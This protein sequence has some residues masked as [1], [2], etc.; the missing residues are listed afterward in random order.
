MK[1]HTPV[2][3]RQ[4]GTV[5]VTTLMCL[6]FIAVMGLSVLSLTLHGL[7]TTRR[8]ESSTVAFNLAESGLDR[9]LRWLKNQP[10]PPGG[11]AAF[12][13]FGGN[14]TMTGG[15]YNVVVTPDP[16]NMGSSL[17]RYGI[18]AT[19]YAGEEVEVVEL[20]VRQT[21]FGKYA[22]FTDRETSAVSG[23]RIWFFSGDRIR[24]P[25]H[26]NNRSGSEFQINWGGPGPI[27]EDSVTSS[28]SFINYSPSNPN[29]ESQF[30]QIYLAGSRGYELN[31][32]EIA[33]PPSSDIQKVAAWGNN[34]AYPGVN[35]VYTPFQ[36][37]IYI[38][39]D[40]AVTMSVDGSGRQRFVIVQSGTTTTLTVD[41]A[42][43]VI[44]KQVGAGPVV[45][46]PGAG[47][48]VVY[49]TGNITSLS[50]TIANNTVLAGSPP[51]VQHRSA[52]TIATDVNAGRNITVT[53]PIRHQTAYNPALGPNAAANLNPGTLGLIGRNVTVGSGCPTNMEIDAV[54]M[55]GSESTTDGS[56]GVAN[57]NTKVPTG[58]LKV[59]GGIIQKARGAV[60]TLSG[61]LLATGYAKDYHY[62]ARMA[63]NPPPFFP[64]T[65]GYDRL[66]WRRMVDP[67]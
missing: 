5:L 62:D 67:D 37:G 63:D 11:L 21:S 56:F 46:S 3:K 41:K 59:L 29:T 1:G 38:R 44:Y 28:G 17:K 51:T 34:G 57:Y 27:F 65:G 15:H 39:G 16:A 25:A 7:H 52:Y 26:S 9:T 6:M 47:N 42:A 64:T 20:V 60:G 53:G 55:A 19:G 40:A 35:G 58:T 4:K 33:L 18:K 43:D 48:G 8:I 32:D 22:Y 14:Q 24:G 54:I 12:D 23:G 61:G 2:S 45:A 49:C 66:S 31:V 50:G 36:G 10:A 13:P 30:A